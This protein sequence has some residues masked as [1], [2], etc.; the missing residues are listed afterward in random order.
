MKL[1]NLLSVPALLFAAALTGCSSDEITSGVTP[2]QEPSEPAEVKMIPFTATIGDKSS[3]EGSRAL[4]QED[5]YISTSWAVYEQIAVVFNSKKYTATVTEVAANGSAVIS[6]TVPADTPDNQAVDLIYPASAVTDAGAISSTL[7]SAQEGTLSDVASKYDVATASGN[8]SVSG[9]SAT[10]ADQ[11]DFTNSYAI[12]RFSFQ[13]KGNDNAA[14]TGIIGLTIKDNSDNVITTVTLASAAT[15]VYVAMAPI[16]TKSKVKFALTTSSKNYEGTANARLVAGSYYPITL[17]LSEAAAAVPEGALSGQFSVSATKKVLFSKG[18]LRYYSSTWSFFDN[19]WDYYDTYSAS[20]WDKF[21]WSTSATTY[22]M[23][24][25]TNYSDYSGDFV[26][27]GATMGSGW[28]TLS[29]TEWYHLFNTRTVNGGTG[30]GYSYTLGQSV[31]GKLGVV[32]YPDDYTGSQYSGSDWSTFESAGCVFLPAAGF[33]WGDSV[34]DAGD[35]GSYWSST[36]YDESYAYYVDFSSGSLDAGNDN[37]RYYGY[38]VRLV[39]V[40]E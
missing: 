39:R 31:N 28:F 33:R 6:G 40:A 37:D 17:K 14:I 3:N 35:Y 18:N 1:K 15:E 9:T 11:V 22:G 13:D 29:T 34:Y 27:W 2:A 10:L 4:S 24:K 25:S 5:G 23:S 38:S 7:L 8:L 12:C 32:I 36:A 19:Q 16:A 30:E 26:D 20:S 21:G